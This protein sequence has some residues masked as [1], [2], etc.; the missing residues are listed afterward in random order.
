[1]LSQ[2]LASLAP[3]SAAAD[4]DTFLWLDIFA[5][6]QHLGFGEKLDLEAAGACIVACEAGEDFESHFP[7]F[8]QESLSVP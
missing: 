4:N 1:M 5:T 8:P 2:V 3:S 6:S 7:I